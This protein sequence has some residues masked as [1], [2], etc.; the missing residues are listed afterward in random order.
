MQV[1]FQ[2]S[3]NPTSILLL[4]VVLNPVQTFLILFVES[5][6]LVNRLFHLDFKL[7]PLFLE[8]LDL[9]FLAH[10]LIDGRVNRIQ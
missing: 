2:Q 1:D 4:K 10:L 8:L 3:F 6:I 5:R 7:F 9:V